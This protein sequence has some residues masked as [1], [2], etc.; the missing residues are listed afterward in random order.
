MI[1]IWDRIRISP[2]STKIVTIKKWEIEEEK[3]KKNKKETKN[4]TGTK[5][6]NNLHK[7]NNKC[8]DKIQNKQ[9]NE[10]WEKKKKKVLKK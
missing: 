6:K 3:K 10:N 9:L 1:T 5:D 4:K 8:I 2:Q 7:N